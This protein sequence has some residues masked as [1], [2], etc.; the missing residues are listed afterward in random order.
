MLQKINYRYIQD[1]GG[2]SYR[3]APPTPIQHEWEYE[4]ETWKIRIVGTVL[5]ET[6]N[7]EEVIS[8]IKKDIKE[9][10][11]QLL[12]TLNKNKK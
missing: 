3:G 11:T 12:T 5:T 1:I 6:Y 4:A 10:I 8:K 9:Q 2:E 7:P